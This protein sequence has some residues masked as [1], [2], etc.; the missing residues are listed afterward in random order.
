VLAAVLGVLVCAGCDHGPSRIEYLDLVT[1]R[2]LHADGEPLQ[3]RETFAADETWV[4]VTLESG[5]AV[6]AE[7]DLQSEPALTLA[8]SLVCAEVMQPE[9]GAIL[10]GIIDAG[11]GR[12]VRFSIELDLA[13]GWWTREVDLAR[14]ANRVAGFRLEPAMPEGCV[15]KLREATVRHHRAVSPPLAEPPKQVL[16]I[17]VD[18]LRYDAIGAFDGTE[19]T[20]N[21]D[22]L[23]AESESFSRH[24]AAASWTKPSHGSMLTGF[25]PEVHRAQLADQAMDP[26]IPTLAERFREAG[27]STAA[28]VFDCGWLSPRWGFGKGFDSYR[29]NQ[30]RAARQARA[31]TDWVLAH[32]NEPFFFFLHTFEPHSDLNLLPYEAPGVNQSI[33]S[34]QFGVRNFGCRQERCA[35]NFLEGLHQGSV[36]REPLDAEILQDTYSAGVQY[37]DEALGALFDDL[38]E[39]GMWEQLLVVVTSDHGEE[40]NDHGGFGHHTL[41]DEITRVPLLVKWPQGERA[42]STRD[43]VCTAVDLAP[44][45]LEFAGGRTKDLQGSHLHRS[46]SDAPIFSGTLDRAV[47]SDGY[48]AIFSYQP[49]PVQLFNLDTDPQELTN[50]AEVE[51]GRVRVLQEILRVQDERDIA[52]WQRIGSVLDTRGV[53]LSDSERERL[54]AFGYLS[55]E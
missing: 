33:I 20:P 46:R 4:A 1:T 36:T 6:T 15:V 34:E 41:Y 50:L 40:F 14:A 29:V 12:K 30:W 19:A 18:T 16:L 39:S 43:T 28:M 23:V 11:D 2:G 31:T 22:R 8:G 21:L 25:Y 27:F 45:L 7:L 24:Y 35:S 48:K 26:S 17:S 55:S 54:K 38:R 9:S 5:V 42:G 32:R 49:K 52:L 13:G 51:P 3:A 53:V 44:T 10:G 37:L 47:V